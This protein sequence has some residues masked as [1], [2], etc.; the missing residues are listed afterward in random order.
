M[1]RHSLGLDLDYILPFAGIPENDREI[2]GLDAHR[3]MLV[4]L[5]RTLESTLS[6]RSLSRLS[7]NVGHPRAGVNICAW[8][9][10]SLGAYFLIDILN[11]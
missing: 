2:D 10:P 3:M 7:S 9:V 4:N 8:Q 11:N 5:L 1:W 6:P